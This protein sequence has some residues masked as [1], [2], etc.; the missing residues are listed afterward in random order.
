MANVIL[1]DTLEK[2]GNKQAKIH[3]LSLKI[4]WWKMTSVFS[5]L[6]CI[7]GNMFVYI[8]HARRCTVVKS[9]LEGSAT[10]NIFMYRNS[11]FL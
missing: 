3:Y 8:S 1:E 2:K 11:T 5:L 10:D 9:L 6:C 4:K 7:F